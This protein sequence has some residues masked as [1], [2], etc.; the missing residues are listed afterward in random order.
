MRA[1]YADIIVIFCWKRLQ[2]KQVDCTSSSFM[3]PS[4]VSSH[5]NDVS[6]AATVST[7]LLYA[8]KSQEKQQHLLETV[9]AG[10]QVMLQT[11]IAAL[12]NLILLDQP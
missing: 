1:L 12:C 7:C 11:S 6:A 4:N 5:H 10:L 2:I 8:G 9:F 3:L